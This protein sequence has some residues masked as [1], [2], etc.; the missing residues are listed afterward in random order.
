MIVHTEPNSRNNSQLTALDRDKWIERILQVRASKL[1]G[2]AKLV[3]TALALNLDDT[4]RCERS[5]EVIADDCGIDLRSVRRMIRKLEAACWLEVNRTVG[6]R[7]NSFVIRTPDHA[8][9]PS[10][11]P[12]IEERAHV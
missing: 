9:Q 4:G 2:A 11:A 3:A 8:N 12:S 5:T 10:A 1:S 7:P 6:S